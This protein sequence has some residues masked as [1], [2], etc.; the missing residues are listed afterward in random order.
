MLKVRH[1][2]VLHQA[3]QELIDINFQ[4]ERGQAIAVIGANGSGKSAML[5]AIADPESPYEGEV[6]LNHYSAK[7]ES[8]KYKT[9]VGYLPGRFSVPDHLTGFEYLELVGTFYQLPPK[10]RSEKIIRLSQLLGLQ[11]SIYSLGERL[12]KVS[13]RQVGL[14]GS[15][16]ADPSLV[17]WDEPTLGFDP[18]NTADVGKLLKGAL[19]H[20]S[21]ALIATT[22][23]E[24]A[25]SVADG[26]IFLKDGQLVADGTLT[27]LAHQAQTSKRLAS[28]YQRL[29]HG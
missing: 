27:Q 1:L 8:D 22:D 23:L 24:F 18:N 7:G 6:K 29:A 28:V 2:S 16:I 21:S 13:Q 5:E 17:I 4:I 9:Q 19:H 12:S 10:E 20:G 3:P 15:V 14:L 26:Y 11:R 25:E